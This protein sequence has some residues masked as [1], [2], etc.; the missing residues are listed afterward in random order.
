MN[1]KRRKR[2]KAEKKEKKKEK[3]FRIKKEE[4]KIKNAKFLNM[5]SFPNLVN[6]PVTCCGLHYISQENAHLHF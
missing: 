1:K 2:A 5:K 4:D 3:E 6:R